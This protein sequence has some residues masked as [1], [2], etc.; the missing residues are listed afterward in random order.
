MRKM[1]DFEV[2]DFK[3]RTKKEDAET[4]KKRINGV[5]FFSNL[6]GY[7]TERFSTLHDFSFIYSIEFYLEN[8][9]SFTLS[10]KVDEKEKIL[11]DTY[12]HK[13]NW[14]EQNKELESI[15]AKDKSLDTVFD[16]LISWF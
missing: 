16:E 10:F 9:W 2:Y 6:L 8:K 15:R 1:E 11:I 5:N 14:Y 7:R 13:N 4:I 12:I 3:M